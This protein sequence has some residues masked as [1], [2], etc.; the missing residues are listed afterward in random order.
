D[1]VSE[2]IPEFPN[3]V[4]L[5]IGRTNIARELNEMVERLNMQDHVRF[6]G[7]IMHKD[8]PAYLALADI[9]VR[10]GKPG[11][12]N[13]SRLPSKLP[14]YMAMGKPIITFSVGFGQ[15]LEDGEEV[16]KTYTESS[17]ELRDLIKCLLLDRELCG[18]LGAN[19]RRKAA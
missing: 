1:A 15:E 3:L 16:L 12:F 9:L 18:R 4:L 13:E 7:P 8:V 11:V 19:A 17:A 6:V 2:L 5:H 14:E 10:T